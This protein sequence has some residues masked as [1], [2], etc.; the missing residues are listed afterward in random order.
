V[1]ETGV[2]IG[3]INRLLHARFGHDLH[4]DG[5]LVQT[6]DGGLALTVRGDGVPAATFAGG[7]SDLGKLTTEAAEHVYG[8]SQPFQFATYLYNRGRTADALD[9]IPGAYVR[10]PA[11]QR[12]KFANTWGNAY[13]GHG[14][15]AK[16]VEKYR[17]AMSLQPRFWKA[18][19]NLVDALLMLDEESAWREGRAIMQAAATAPAD[20]RPDVI[21]LD[22]WA[23]ASQDW[24]LALASDLADAAHNNGAGATNSIDG[25]QIADN[26]TYLHDPVKAEQYLA[27]S[28]PD[29]SYTKAE[30]SLLS[31]T[32]ALEHGDAA[33]AVAPLEVLWKAWLADPN[34]QAT[35]T[36]QPCRLALAYGLSGRLV[37]AEAVFKRAGRWAYCYGVHGDVLERAGDLAGAQRVWA[38]GIKIGPDLSPVYLHRGI[39]E[40]KR[41]ALRA[42][43]ADLAAA[44]ARSP[45]WADPLKAWGDALMRAGNRGAALAKYNQALEYAPAWAELHQARDAAA[46]QR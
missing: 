2:S 17:L 15:V 8:R 29:D 11:D 7:A 14:D 37:Q 33:A 27:A 34:L 25:P 5:D 30:T 16:G 32:G 1:P 26:Y 41:G 10:A 22:S 44:H 46:R 4:I 35:F 19:G 21:Y 40:T 38:D 31:G 23:Q 43:L 39:S 6:T 42:A 28:D 12:A 18:W 13:L 20:D 36:E 3:E 45:H 24:P 9:F